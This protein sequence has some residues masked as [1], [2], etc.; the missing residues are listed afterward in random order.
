[1]KKLLT[2]TIL[3]LVFSVISSTD[4]EAVFR[5]EPIYS[6]PIHQR[7]RFSADE[8]TGNGA[9]SYSIPVPAGTNDLAPEVSLDYSSSGA[10]DLSVVA[11][12]GWSLRRNSIEV[13]TNFTPGT[14]TDD[15]FRLNFQGSNQELVYFSNDTRYHTKE[16]SNLSIKKL[17][18]GSNDSKSYWQVI[19]K[20]GTKYS[21][22]S[23]SSS[24]LMCNGRSYV[25]SWN[26]DQVEDT[27]GNKI[28][29]TYTESSGSAFLNQIKY[30][31]D[32][33]RTVN[34]NYQTSPYN[35][36]VTIQGC[37]V[38]EGIR[39][40]NIETKVSGSLVKKFNLNYSLSENTQ[41]LLSSVT[42]LGN[43]GSTALQPTTFEYEPEVEKW[44]T[45]S[46]TWID[47]GDI[48]VS[49][50]H[51][52]MVL[53]DVTGD[54]LS[55]IVQSLGT[56]GTNAT[57]RVLINQGDSWASTWSI[58]V[59]NADMADARLARNENDV[60]VLDVD[61]D[62][63]A[64]IVKSDAPHDGWSTYKVWKN[65]GN[66]WNTTYET[67]M[68]NALID[69]SFTDPGVDL[70]DVTGDNLPD[71][72]K[73]RSSSGSTWTVYKNTGSSWSTTGET[74][75]NNGS[76]DVMLGYANVAMF[77]A[78][79]D[80][81]QDIVKTSSSSRWQIWFN[82]GNSWNNSLV[83][84]LPTDSG[85]DAHLDKIQATVSDV[86][87]DNLPDIVKSIPGEPW[88]VLL[89]KGNTWPT[90]WENWTPT[91]LDVNVEGNNARLADVTGDGLPDIVKTEANGGAYVTWK[92]WKNLG[93]APDLLKKV[94]TPQGGTIAIDYINSTSFDNTGSNSISDLPF[95]IWLVDSITK[96]N[97]MVGTQA[98]TETT[99]YNYL[100]GFYD[101]QDKEF[102]GF[103]QVSTI[104]P[105]NAKKKYIFYQDDMFKGKLWQLTA[106]DS[107]S[108]PFEKIV[109]SWQGTASGS[110]YIVNLSQEDKYTH[111]GDV[112]NPKVSRTEYQYDNYGNVTKISEKGDTS[113]GTDDRFIYNEYVYNFS[114]WI[115]D[116]AKKTYKN[117]SNDSTKVSETSLYYDDNSS[118]TDLPTKG[119]VTKTEKWLNGGS[120][121]IT[122][123]DYDSYGNI[124]EITDANENTT[125]YSF[126][127]NDTTYTYPD[128]VTNAKAQ[129]TE[130]LYDLGT[131]NLLSKTDP[132]D[133]TTI[134]AYDIFGRIV[135]EIKEYDSAT[136]PTVIY[137]YSFDGVAPE[138]TMT[139]RLEVSSTSATL[140][141]YTFTD[142]F[143]RT[144]QALQDAEDTGKRI[145]TETFYDSNGEVN[146]Q[147][148]PHLEDITT[149]YSTPSALLKATSTTYDIL[150]RPLITTNPDTTTNIQEYDHWKITKT[151]ERG[152]EM[153][154]YLNAF[155]KIITVEEINGAN[156]YTTTYDYNALDALTKI[157]DDE[158]NE[159]TITYDTLGRKTAQSDPDMGNWTYAY[160]AVG[161][162]TSQTDARSVTTTRTYDELDR[163]T[164]INY[165]TDT[166]TSY[167]YDGNSKKGTLTSVTDA[168]GSI[169]FTYD[170]RLR[171]L[172]EA[173]TVGS[174]TKTTS[175]AYDA[176][177]R[178][179]TQ[180]NPDSEAVAY[181]FNTQGEIETVN[182]IMDD[183]D[184]NALG[185]ITEKTF[186]NG[187]TT[188]YTY[189]TDDFRLNA[190]ETGS[191]QDLSY[192]YDNV[193]NVGTRVNNLTS[194]TET[195]TYDDLDRL[196]TASETSGYDYEYDY[197]SIGNLTKFT[198]DGD[199]TDYTYGEDPA[200]P[201][202]LTSKSTASGSATPAFTFSDDWSSGSIN[203]TNWDNWGSPQ[204]TVISNQLKIN[205]T[206]T[207]DGYY[208]I[209]SNSAED[210][211][212]SYTSSQLI[213]A[214]NQSL[215]S[216]QVIPLYVDKTGDFSNAIIYYVQG[217]N[218]KIQKRVNNSD[219]FINVGSYNSST[220][221]Y[222]RIRESGGTTY[223]DTSADGTTWSNVHSFS[224]A[225]N[226]TSVKVG[227]A[228]GTI[229]SEASTTSAIFDNFNTP[230]VSTS[231]TSFSYDANGNMTDDGDLKLFEYN[232]ANQLKK[233]KLATNSATIAEYLYDYTGLRTIKKNYTG[234]T[235]ANTITSW[236]ESFETKEASGSG[237][238]SISLNG[239]VQTNR[240]SGGNITLS[241]FP[242]NGSNSNRF[243]LVAVG[244]H[245]GG[246]STG[247]T[248]VT[249][250]GTAMTQL[251][252]TIGQYGEFVELW[253]LQAPAGGTGNIVTSGLSG[254]DFTF[255]A[256]YSL[257][258]VKQT[259]SVVTGTHSQSSN[260]SSINITP[261]S[262][263]N[264][265]IDAIEAEPVPSISGSASQDWTLNGVP[266]SYNNGEGSH[267]AQSGGPTQVS[268]SWGLSY[269]ARSNHAA[270][271]LEPAP[272]S[273][274]ETTVYY[275]ANKELVAKKDNSGNKTYFHNDH[276]GSTSVVTNQAGSVVETTTYDPWGEIISGSTASKFLY[277]G[278]EHDGETG[279]HYYNAR[280]YNPD[281]RRFTQPDS[282]IQ[283]VHN[284][285]NLNRYSYVWNNPL[286][287]TDPTGNCVGKILA[288]LCSIGPAVWSK[289]VQPVLNFVIKQAT[290]PSV[291]TSVKQ[292]TTVIN[293]NRTTTNIL[294][295]TSRTSIPP[296]ATQTATKG[297]NQILNTRGS[298]TVYR[299]VDPLS[300]KTTYIGKTVN[301]E[302]RQGEWGRVGREIEPIPGLDK[303]PD[304]VLRA[305][306]QA[307]IERHGL[308][309]LDNIRNSISPSNPIYSE[310][311]KIGN[312]LLDKMGY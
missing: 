9:Y 109:N 228:L 32:E 244:S 183:F 236:T 7:D 99:E 168:A 20:D 268:M 19:T 169:S 60:R 201:H 259:Y 214:G 26:L 48:D 78:N 256:A 267:I 187:L 137:S 248:G 309:N 177:D 160:D 194:K 272:S 37:N 154:D 246:G 238:G 307:A 92:I 186:D 106:S 118:L 167:T 270:V 286:K 170:N 72:V 191:I 54:G 196:E 295:T 229:S 25:K 15:K 275:Y 90:T 206:T 182:G 82:T 31:N 17:P 216:L 24:E 117:A 68:S 149:Q 247:A 63:L 240:N 156:T 164:G 86:N 10:R 85:I 69:A 265:I 14:T 80:G 298:G 266:N 97:G 5:S 198:D 56:G 145:A 147:T 120:N 262:A 103:E 95:N 263:N 175:F 303:L 73:S 59:N 269:G 42:E 91:Y 284:P 217:N 249:Y 76:I 172:T 40:A 310:S 27:Y 150:N 287:Y 62:G 271:A 237:G 282:L 139:A 8:F 190:I 305:V 158:N 77:D 67:W 163:I 57:W 260:S 13:D 173:R 128:S 104:E 304:K 294:N 192:T 138:R 306:E 253:G 136:Y 28:Y 200:G 93:Y 234:G 148:V 47:H 276:L 61:G 180:T 222:F 55:D 278:Q 129:T 146:K 203:G 18:T 288:T 83:E 279:L 125:E 119:D 96:R 227:L 89:N 204:T 12:A 132:N 235:L 297:L 141:T 16:E 140:D 252:Q 273:S 254:G 285:Q 30:N 23:T 66:S 230:T 250:G 135:K 133:F 274:I 300:N 46:A 94:T 3:C 143:G 184:Y 39:L 225:F 165:P 134:Y 43:D 64:D 220:H 144:V 188:E 88:R 74:W 151:N 124:I 296:S 58:W 283:E 171:R 44:S 281:I 123:L 174:T 51:D 242:V 189:D 127:T 224:N 199:D 213:N 212:G 22:G 245:Q 202:A 277:T 98:T 258:N 75:L 71:I 87:G 162:L 49:L 223:F 241:S 79:G 155:G 1:M 70:Y 243:L 178:I 179:T 105:N 157:T 166:D 65:T 101:Y 312:G 45:Q 130:T 4:A 210:L 81:L 302:R 52:N 207:A 308:E 226:M 111:D 113:T 114:S 21:F 53:I 115:I 251:V 152:K 197:N 181:T 209:I 219:T 142:G 34:F 153:N 239:S 131:G 41:P 293:N 122:L 215:S 291:Q 102:R 211:T 159:F 2:H 112:S 221:K 11:G 195:F 292:T 126:G 107:A 110:A 311:I 100:N 33:T 232:E 299:T 6:P 280:Y 290:K 36:P 176:M 264:W 121:P 208:G 108:N 35:R 38:F 233:V 84:W 50:V 29:F 261:S 218:I 116:K 301:F 231:T 205:S 193:G 161:N 185:K 257:Y 255:I 289:A